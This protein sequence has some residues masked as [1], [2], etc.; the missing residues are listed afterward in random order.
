MKLLTRRGV[1]VEEEDSTYMADIDGDSDEARTHRPL[2]ATACTYRTAFGPRAGQKVLTLLGAM[3]RE[4]DFKQILCADSS[5]FGLH[6]AERCGADDRQALEQLCR[7]ITRQALD[8]RARKDQRRRAGGAQAQ[9]SLARRHHPPGDV[10]AGIQ[11]AAA[12]QAPQSALRRRVQGRVCRL[13]VE[14]S[15]SQD[16]TA[17]VRNART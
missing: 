14:S 13:W 9:D 5:G 3:P 4:T 1:L 7:Y 11:E 10:V 12:A 6:A 17:A 16:G 2:Q 15:S 8:R